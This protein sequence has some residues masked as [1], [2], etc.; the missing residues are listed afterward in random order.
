MVPDVDESVPLYGGEGG[1]AGPLG[2]AAPRVG[3]IRT[4]TSA[5]LNHNDFLSTIYDSMSFS[6]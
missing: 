3:D 6:N 4:L 5:A 2:E 1:E